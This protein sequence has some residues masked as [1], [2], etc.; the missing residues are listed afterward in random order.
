[1]HMARIILYGFCNGLEEIMKWLKCQW[2]NTETY[3]TT[4]RMNTQELN[5]E[6]QQNEDLCIFGEICPKYNIGILMG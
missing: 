2:F 4:N 6:P 3:G 5:I 1:M